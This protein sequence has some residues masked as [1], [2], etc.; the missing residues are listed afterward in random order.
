METDMQEL[1]A[2]FARTTDE[3][4]MRKLLDELLTNAEREDLSLR[5]NLMNQLYQGTSQREIASQ[6]GI[7]LCKITRGS[8][9]LKDPNSYCRSLLSE[10]YDDH[11]HI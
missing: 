5:W 6:L 7:S 9:I 1:V 3:Q 8:R 4:Q 2:I 10:K 11:L